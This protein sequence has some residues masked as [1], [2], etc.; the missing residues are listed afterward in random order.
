LGFFA[1]SN[2]FSSSGIHLV[3]LKR[4]VMFVEN[5]TASKSLRR[6]WLTRT[7]ATTLLVALIVVSMAGW[8][9]FLGKIG[10]A[11]FDWI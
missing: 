2:L 9:Y 11:L 1:R 4:T 7:A 6:R 5:L 10:R 3:H 8:L